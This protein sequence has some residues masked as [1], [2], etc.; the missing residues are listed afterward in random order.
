MGVS[1]RDRDRQRKS[2]LTGESASSTKRPF[3]KAIQSATWGRAG[4]IADALGLSQSE[5][6]KWGQPHA[7]Q[8]GP[9]WQLAIVMQEALDAGADECDALAPLRL[10]N[11]MFERDP[12]VELDLLAAASET[13]REVVEPGAV[14]AEGLRD[15]KWDASDQDRLERETA[16]AQLKL[17]RQLAAGRARLA[18]QNVTPIRKA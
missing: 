14:V 6:E 2:D 15:G 18:K 10:L 1:F 16:E 12:Q 4:R 13:L 7:P 9:C 11:S 3:A 17:G 8:R 5:V